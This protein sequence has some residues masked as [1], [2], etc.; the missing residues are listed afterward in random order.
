M[1]T[2]TTRQARSDGDQTRQLILETAGLLFAEQGYDRTTSKAICERAGVNMA[3]INYHFGGKDGLYLAVLKEIHQRMFSLD[4]L[5]A[6]VEQESSPEQKLR[7]VVY[8]IIDYIMDNENWHMR[9]WLREVSNPSPL[10]TQL[11]AENLQPKFD[12]GTQL[13]TQIIGQTTDN[14]N[15]KPLQLCAMSPFMALAMISGT[16]NHPLQEILHMDSNQLAEQICSFIMA[17][18]SVNQQSA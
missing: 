8:Q 1:N 15:V 6:L 13:V 3:S 4:K 7:T 10:W 16:P 11:V 9:L 5:K 12:L 14:P 17:G 18:L 2:P